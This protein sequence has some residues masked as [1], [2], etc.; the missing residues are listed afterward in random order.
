MI[1]GFVYLDEQECQII[2]RPEFQRL[3]R[4][5]QLAL[6]HMVYPGAMHTRFEHSIGVMHMATEMFNSIIKN[7]Q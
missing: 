6:T 2:D 3:R 7:T 1:Y 5:K 4:I